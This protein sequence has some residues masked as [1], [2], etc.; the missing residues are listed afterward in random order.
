M[1]TKDGMFVVSWNHCRRFTK[2]K[3]GAMETVTEQQRRQSCDRIATAKSCFAI[4][5]Y[6]TDV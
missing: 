4:N 6:D 2:I 1:D 3:P 5:T